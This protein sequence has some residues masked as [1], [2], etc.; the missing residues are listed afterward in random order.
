MPYR[1]KVNF[2][3]SRLEAFVS[4]EVF[5]PGKAE[6]APCGRIVYRDFRIVFMFVNALILSDS[7]AIPPPVNRIKGSDLRKLNFQL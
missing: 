2:I 5:Q 4:E 7:P 1:R 3:F 6:F